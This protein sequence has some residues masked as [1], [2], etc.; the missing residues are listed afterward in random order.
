MLIER[1]DEQ[2]V[3]LRDLDLLCCE[4]LHQIGIAADP[5]DSIAARDRLFSSPT[6][7]REPELDADWKEYVEPGLAHLF[8]S[9]LDVVKQDL[10]DFPPA[11]P[12]D[13]YTLHIPVKHLESWIHA[14][15]QARLAIAARHDFT[16]REMDDK[17]PLSGDTRA[18]ALF[19]VYFYGILQEWFLAELE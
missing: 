15:N 18:F 8:R 11:T 5:G 4:L 19:Q 2:T 17:V 6:G 7:G 16:Q 1:P 13:D 12:A 10:R 14:L 3:A 9:A